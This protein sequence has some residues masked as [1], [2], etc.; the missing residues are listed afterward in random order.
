MNLQWSVSKESA[1]LDRAGQATNRRVW[2]IT[3]DLL[4]RLLKFELT[5]N[6]ML[7]AV[8]TLWQREGSIP[9]GGPFSAQSADLHTLWKVKRAGKNLRDWGALNISDEGYVYRQRGP[10][11]FSLCQFRDNILFAS[12]QQPGTHT[13]VIQ[14]VAETLSRVWDLE[15]LCPCTDGGG[16]L[17]RGKLLDP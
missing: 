3:H 13:H 2:C 10:L 11:W 8:G 16:G 1:K 7:Q 4:T 5:E 15:V 12:N 17:L 14:T 9:M 6:N